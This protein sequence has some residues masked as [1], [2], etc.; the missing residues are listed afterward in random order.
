[1]ELSPIVIVLEQITADDNDGVL[2]SRH[3]RACATDTDICNLISQLE[4]CFA[5]IYSQVREKKYQRLLP[6]HR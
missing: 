1:M 6:L 4:G 3:L 5:F 2:L